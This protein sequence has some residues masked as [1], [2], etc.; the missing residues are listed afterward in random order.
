MPQV[1]SGELWFRLNRSNAKQ[2]GAP[3]A[4]LCH[5]KNSTEPPDHVH[6]REYREYS[7]FVV[8][9]TD[10]RCIAPFLCSS[11]IA[12]NSLYHSGPRG[13]LLPVSWIVQ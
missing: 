10:V 3:K 12:F 9:H 2:P 6:K 13:L 8:V 11:S 1:H 7:L 5:T 4:Y